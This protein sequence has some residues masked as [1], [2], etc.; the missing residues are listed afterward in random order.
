VEAHLHVDMRVEEGFIS[1]P[2]DIDIFSYGLAHVRFNLHQPFGS[3][4]GS[5]PIFKRALGFDNGKDQS[6]V[7]PVRAALPLDNPGKLLVF[8]LREA[9]LEP[10]EDTEN[11]L[12]PSE[13]LARI[14]SRHLDYALPV[15]DGQQEPGTDIDHPDG[16]EKLPLEWLVFF[17]INHFA[18]PK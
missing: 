13:L 17:G 8:G 5:G 18:Q 14:N 7:L 16:E 15:E 6:V 10:L 2:S 1:F 3:L 11:L 9:C 4:L 12:F